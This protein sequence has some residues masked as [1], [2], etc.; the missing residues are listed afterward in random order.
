[1]ASHDRE[2][3]SPAVT[4]ISA[5]SCTLTSGC[6]A[7]IRLSLQQYNIVHNAEYH[8][9]EIGGGLSAI[10]VGIYFSN[11]E[12]LQSHVPPTEVCW[13]LREQHNSLAL[14]E[15]SNRESGK[16]HKKNRTL[17]SNTRIVVA[18]VVHSDYILESLQKSSIRQ[19]YRDLQVG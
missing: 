5:E 1:M 11:H 6:S 19:R 2:M 14:E 4:G 10:L 3:E 9:V 17:K 12:T 18:F 13:W 8:Q 16:S 7:A 15:V